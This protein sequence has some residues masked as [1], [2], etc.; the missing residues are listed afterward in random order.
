M[1]IVISPRSNPSNT[2]GVYSL[3]N[4]T[5]LQVI[6]NSPHVPRIYFS[7]TSRPLRW[8]RISGA[9][10]MVSRALPA[11]LGR[12]QGRP[13]IPS[14]DTAPWLI[15]SA[16]VSSLRTRGLPPHTAPAAS[17]VEASTNSAHEL[18]QSQCGE[19]LGTPRN[20]ESPG[21]EA[22]EGG[23]VITGPGWLQCPLVR[24]ESDRGPPAS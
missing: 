12:D 17:A 11:G 15:P 2:I 4:S 1:I 23:A 22:G 5:A 16:A 18:Q 6:E 3:P 8:P 9:M 24:P 14:R 7:T 19:G 20:R 21:R 13:P 10:S